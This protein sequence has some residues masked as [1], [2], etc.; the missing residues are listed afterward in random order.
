M[1]DDLKY[2]RKWIKRNV[3]SGLYPDMPKQIL[4]L[5]KVLCSQ[6]HS[7]ESH[8]LAINYFLK[9]LKAYDDEME[10]K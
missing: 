1:K 8:R 3:Q 6:R 9:M 10:A 5:A 7:G 2:Y 4:A